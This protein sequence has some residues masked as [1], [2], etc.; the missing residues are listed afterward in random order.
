MFKSLLSNRRLMMG[1]VIALAFAA[2]LAFSGC[3]NSAVPQDVV[4][5]NMGVTR[6]NAQKNADSYFPVL[7][8]PGTVDQ[9]IGAKP[10]RILMQSDSTVSTTCRFGDGWASGN[11]EFEN[12]AKLKVK[13]QTNG[14]GKGINGCMTEAEFVTKPYKSE[15][16]SCQ[17][18]SALDKFK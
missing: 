13:C 3:G 15:E 14:T 12:G 6:N 18:L 1:I 7:Y 17:N 16:G 8:P 5:I 11:V 9:K 4:D 2:L 10:T